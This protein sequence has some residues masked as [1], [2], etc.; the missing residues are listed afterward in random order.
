MLAQ[1]K[2]LIFWDY[3]RG[4]WQYDIIVVSITAFVFLTPREWFHDQAR[5]P[6]SSQ[7][8][9]LPSHGEGVFWIEP[10]LVGPIPEAQRVGKLSEVLTARTGKRQSIAR[11]EPIY[12]SERE[13]KGYM[14]FARP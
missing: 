9:S 12:D 10:E 4:S 2:R 3:P 5:I 7:I 13:L 1:L 11:I 14:A 6:H 8:A